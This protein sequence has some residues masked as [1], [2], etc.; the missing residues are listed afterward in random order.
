IL[1]QHQRNRVRDVENLVIIERAERRAARRDIVLIGFLAARHAWTIFVREHVDHAF[2]GKRFAGVDAR[3]PAFCNA[4][5]NERTV[6]KIVSRVFG[7]VFRRAGHLG[8]A[9][10]ARRRYADVGRRAAHRIFLSAWDCGVPRAAWVSARTIARRASSI[11]KALCGKPRALRNSASAARRKISSS[12]FCPSSTASASRSR[13]G[14]CA[15][16]PSAKRACLIVP[17]SNSTP[18][19]IETSANAYDSRSRSFR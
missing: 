10:D 1:G 13:Q 4:R 7:G 6:R 9:V 11:L 8:A 17:P 3:D 16:P 12:G 2:D 5:G 19:A 14:L 18:T 15:T